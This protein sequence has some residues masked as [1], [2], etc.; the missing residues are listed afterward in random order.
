VQ[1]N[2]LEIIQESANDLLTIINDILDLEKIGTG[3]IQLEKIPFDIVAKTNTIIKLFELTAKNK[4]TT[5]VFNNKIGSSLCVVG[6]PTKYN[7]VLNNLISNA[8]K[9]THQGQITVDASIQEEAKD[10]VTLAFSVKDTG[11]GIDTNQIAKIFE[12]FTQAYPETT[13]KYGGTGLGLAITKNLLELQ[14]GNIWVDSKP[15]KGS[16]FNFSIPY[17]KCQNTKTS[18]K[19]LTVENKLGSLKILVAEDNEINQLL[20]KSMLELWGFQTKVVSTG[21]EV[22]ELMEKENFD[23]IL[24]DIHMPEKNGYETT[25]EIRALSNHDK[26]NIPIIALTANALQGEEAKYYAVGMNGFLTKP[27]SETALYEAIE[28]V[29]T[30]PESF[31]AGQENQTTPMEEVNTPKLYDLTLVNE[32]AR[33]SA[34]FILN[35][36]K[37]FIDTV[38]PTSKE[39]V[40]A[41]EKKN[42]E[43]VGKLAH[44]LKSTIDTMCISS[45]KDDIRLIEKNGKDKKNIESIPALVEKADKIISQVTEQLKV[46]FKL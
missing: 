10:N 33:G 21:T 1:R 15:R 43:Q 22:I 28:K 14:G 26:K 40:A 41:C 19:K 38:P 44:K 17:S 13:R 42:W 8:V 12:P 3:N 7:Q 11:I 2:Y 4:G 18:G 36:S 46:E 5:I 29:I 24:M 16:S 30:K 9:F 45:L 34:E 23:I 20:T 27:F 31:S 6:D 37:I 35:L 39:M 25:S 32:L